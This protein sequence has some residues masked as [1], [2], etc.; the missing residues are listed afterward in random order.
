M[1]RGSGIAEQA[2]VRI[3]EDPPPSQSETHG[4]SALPFQRLYPIMST[5]LIGAFAPEVKFDA[6]A[7]GK[8]HDKL[9]A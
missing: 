7:Q 1:S 3:W 6:H 4:A 9:K 2:L 5:L 8:E